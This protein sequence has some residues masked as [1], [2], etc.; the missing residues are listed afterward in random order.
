MDYHKSREYLVSLKSIC[1]MLFDKSKITKDQKLHFI[2]VMIFNYLKRAL[3]ELKIDYSSIEIEDCVNLVPLYEYTSVNEIELYDLE[4][5]TLDDV[6][7]KQPNDVERFVLS[8]IFYMFK[9]Q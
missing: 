6:D 9:K 1:N 5:I 7:V 8:H 4:K 2:S 3:E